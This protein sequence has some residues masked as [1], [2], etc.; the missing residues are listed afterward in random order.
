MSAKNDKCENQNDGI[1]LYSINGYEYYRSLP[2]YIK[3]SY[4]LKRNIWY[5]LRQ[6]RISEEALGEVGETIIKKI[7]DEE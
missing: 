4:W 1:V 3:F 2:W 7:L 5:R 6:P